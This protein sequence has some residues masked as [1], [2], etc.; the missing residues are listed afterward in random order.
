[1]QYATEPS[2]VKLTRRKLLI[3]GAAAPLWLAKAVNAYTRE[4]A[5]LTRPDQPGASE[6]VLSI[7]YDNNEGPRGLGSSWGFSCL[8]QTPIRTILFD[9]GEKG[10]L[11]LANFQQLGLD[12]TRIDALVLSHN[13]WDH[14]GGVEHILGVRPRIPVY[15]PAGFPEDFHARLGALE[16]EPVV[17]DAATVICP[18]VVTT[19]ILGKGEIEEHALC[20]RTGDG[21]VMVTGCAHPGVDHLA[22][23]ARQV[24]GAAPHF[25]LGGFHMVEWTPAQ[26]DGVI[27]HFEQEGVQYG[28]PCHCSGNETRA[29]FKDRWGE[30]CILTGVGEVFH[31]PAG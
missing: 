4:S 19:G 12:P 25:V 24:T 2:E 14:T 21:W 16:A 31:L 15:L 7:L 9:T 23:Q 8:I 28:A 13:H 11:L 26:I 1:M 22:D 5:S 29:R 18:G 17:A 3:A 30:R 20:V 6:V 10:D 27:D